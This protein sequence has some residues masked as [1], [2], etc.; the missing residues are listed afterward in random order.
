[1]LIAIWATMLL[2]APDLYASDNRLRKSC[3][4]LIVS[5]HIDYPPFNYTEHETFRGASIDLIRLIARKIG[6]RVEI[7]NVGPWIRAVKN[8][9]DGDIDLLV[10]IYKTPEREARYLYTLPYAED[11]IVMF[12]MADAAFDFRDWYDLVGKVGVTTRGDS[13]GADFDQFI[14]QHLT[15]MRVNTT[16]QMIDM[17]ASKRANYGVQGLYTLQRSER[18]AS[19]GTDITISNTPIKSEKMYMAFSRL[20][21]CR[22]LIDK[23]NAAITDF[24]K[25]KTIARLISNYVHRNGS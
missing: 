22:N 2:W 21:P 20:S 3:H 13:W 18:R 4:Q 9:T 7:R 12:T 8:L 10:A 24:E 19:L 16:D 15:M 1:M 17:I 6:V 14:E 23:V 25:D 5:G 11:P